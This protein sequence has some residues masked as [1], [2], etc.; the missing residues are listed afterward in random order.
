MVAT[1]RSG[2]LPSTVKRSSSSSDDSSSKRQKVDNNN[3]ES[4]EKPKSSLPPPTENPKELASTD[5]PEFDAV[6]PQATSG[7]GET[8]AKI[9]DAPAVSVVAPTTAGAT[10]AIVD[11]PRSSMSLRKQNQGSETTSPWCWLMSEYPQVNF[12][13]SR[14]SFECNLIVVTPICLELMFCNSR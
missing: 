5:P 4:S 9:D 10:P 1:R 7:D 6:T 14:F 13:A 8:T 3:A 2:S 11:K 12:L